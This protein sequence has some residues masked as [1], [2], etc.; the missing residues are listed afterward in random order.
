MEP[1]CLLSTQSSVS[2]HQQ[3]TQAYCSHTE[4]ERLIADY[5]LAPQA[6]ASLKYPPPQVFWF[7]AAVLIQQG[8][9]DPPHSL[10]LR[11]TLRS[12]RVAHSADE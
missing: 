2:R 5:S 7:Y 12:H 4:K 3:F 11:Q 10:P 1:L 8:G 6:T 9:A